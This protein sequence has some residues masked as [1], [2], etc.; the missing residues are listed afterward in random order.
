M[1]NCAGSDRHE[2]ISDLPDRT[3]VFGRP[4]NLKDRRAG[5]FEKEDIAV[6]LLSGILVVATLLL[7]ARVL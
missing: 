3:A 2:S 6:L 1:P 5:R 4:S 7:A